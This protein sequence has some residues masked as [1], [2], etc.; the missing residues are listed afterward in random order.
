MLVHVHV[1]D[2]AGGIKAGEHTELAGTRGLRV[3]DALRMLE[4]VVHQLNIGKRRRLC[5]AKRFRR[6]ADVA[7]VEHEHEHEHEHEALVL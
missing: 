7:A 6:G 3:T 1:L 5:F 2:F 4:V